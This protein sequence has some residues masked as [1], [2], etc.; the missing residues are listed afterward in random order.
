MAKEQRR[1]ARLKQHRGDAGHDNLQRLNFL[2]Q[3]SAYL[4]TFSVPL[5]SLAH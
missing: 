2:H 5:M 3:A 4:C 1:D